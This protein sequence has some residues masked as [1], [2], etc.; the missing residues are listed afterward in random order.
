MA[1]IFTKPTGS[2]FLNGSGVLIDKT[3]SFT[4]P[5]TITIAVPRI[6]A[7]F[8]SNIPT[9]LV[10]AGRVFYEERNTTET[11]KLNINLQQVST[12]T[13][14]DFGSTAKGSGCSC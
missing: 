4:L 1:A 10:A 2:D 3:R 5:S 7:V 11:N 6:Y 13:A 8:R 9:K 12:G 14:L